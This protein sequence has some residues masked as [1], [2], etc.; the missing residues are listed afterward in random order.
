M[1]NIQ[2]NDVSGNRDLCDNTAADGKIRR[3]AGEQHN[4]VLI[5]IFLGTQSPAYVCVLVIFFLS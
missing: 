2:Q 3:R 1:M 4:A 5:I